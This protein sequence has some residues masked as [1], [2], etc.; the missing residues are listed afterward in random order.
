MYSEVFG[1]RINCIYVAFLVAFYDLFHISLE[2]YN[3]FEMFQDYENTDIGCIGNW[4]QAHCFAIYSE[5]GI[6]TM[7]L[8]FTIALIVGAAMVS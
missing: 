5:L 7:D 6:Y 4:K 1:Y 3:R 2:M 8:I